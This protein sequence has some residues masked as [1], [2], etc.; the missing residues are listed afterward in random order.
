MNI[1]TVSF[2]VAAALTQTPTLAAAA[3]GAQS[4][5][6]A[7]SGSSPPLEVVDAAHAV[8]GRYVR[9]TPDLQGAVVLN[10]K[11]YS[12]AIQAANAQLYG[13][14]VFPLDGFAADAFPAY[15]AIGH[16]SSD[17]SGSAYLLVPEAGYVV[18]T[19]V[20]NGSYQ[21]VF[22]PIGELPL[23]RTFGSVRTESSSDCGRLGSPEDHWSV[24]AYPNSEY[25]TGFPLSGYVAPLAI[26]IV[27]DIFVDGF[28]PA[29]P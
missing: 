15:R 24:S 28:D 3:P 4:F 20:Y 21:M 16:L 18:R 19:T 8:V 1:R 27:D 13:N 10:A 22:A 11:G 26:R 25:V 12:F 9:S 5:D 6:A 7:M 23:V 29:A 14:E 17:C 2:I